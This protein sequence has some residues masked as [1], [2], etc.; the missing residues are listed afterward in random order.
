MTIAYD[1]FS[2]EAMK[3]PHP[4]YARLRKE[5]PMYFIEKYNAWAISRFQ[6]VWDASLAQDVTFTSGQTPGQIL[7]GEPV[8]H[9]FMT[10][11][12]PEHRQWRGLVRLEYTPEGVKAHM[13]RIRS[14]TKDILTPLL[15]KGAFDIYADLANK[16]TTIN[17]GYMLGLSKED[18]IQCRQW[19]DG[20]LHREEGQVGGGSAINGQSFGAL[21]GFLAQFVA[22]LR[23]HPEKALRHTK[24]YLEAE[25]DGRRL[26][27]EEITFYLFSLLIT[28]SETTPITVAG[29]IYN[30][31]QNPAQLAQVKADNSLLKKAF[32]EQVRY[33]QPTNM[34]ARK[35]AK[36]MEIGGAQIK[37]GQGLLFLY[38]SAC[39]DEEEFENADKFD[40]NRAPGRELTFGHGGHKCLGVHLGT[41]MGTIIFEEVFAA[42]KSYEVMEDQSQRLY[43]EHLS[44]WGKVPIKI[45]LKK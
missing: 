12:A 42:I 2:H 3:D 16:V 1:P 20:M 5:S 31:A 14:V 21:Y 32:L 38:A 11:D 15:A 9:T 37:A 36:D 8:P 18:A 17:A 30:L 7:L 4:I 22:D 13:D 35:A 28:G 45:A 33:D 26:G 40:I 25:I 10:M 23:A 41:A 43:G 27:D 19:I 44:G 39:R 34:L 24:A 6:D 29:T